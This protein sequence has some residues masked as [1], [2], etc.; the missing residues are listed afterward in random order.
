MTTVYFMF[1]DSPQR[2]L[3]L[4]AEPGSGE[5]YALYGLD[6]LAASGI[7]TRHNL[8]RGGSPPSWARAAGGAAKR[9]LE[10]AGGYGGDFATV[11]ASLRAANRADVVFSTVDTVGIPLMFSK[12]GR[13][14]RPPLV[15]AAIGLLERL[16]RLRTERIRRLYAAALGSAAAVLAYSQYEA[17]ALEAW[18]VRHGRPA[19]VAFVPF[20]VSSDAF[21][22]SD[23]PT[24]VDVVSVGAD[25]HRDYDLLLRVA[26]GRPETTFRLVT[27]GDRARALV[28]PPANVTIESDLPFTEMHTRLAAGRVVALPV[29]D[30]SYSGATTVLLQAMALAKPVVVTRTRAIAAGYGLADGENC[31]LVPPGDVRAFDRALGEVLDDRSRGAELGRAARA[32]VVATL[33]WQRYV[34]Q[35]RRVLLE[36]AESPARSRSAPR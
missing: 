11:L 31:R 34:D 30:N 12:H 9:A 29:R 24:D 25:P 20:G 1:R 13:I 19:P 33:T 28:R 7:S 23:V 21:R 3:A 5:R 32:T 2:R 35:I 18:L 22:P 6:E 17:D 36:A 16:E 10:G 26:E 15:Y 8:E 14:L 4:A 27:A